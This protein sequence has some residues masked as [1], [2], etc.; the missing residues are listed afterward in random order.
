MILQKIFAHILPQT[1]LHL[2]AHNI[3][4][5]TERTTKYTEASL[6]IMAKSLFPQTE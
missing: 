4:K 1:Y 3:I 5:D 2:W 6:Q